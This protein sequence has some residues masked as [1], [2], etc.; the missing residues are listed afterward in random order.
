ME[1][2]EK[3]DHDLCLEALFIFAKDGMAVRPFVDFA[4][5]NLLYRVYL[6]TFE[7]ISRLAWVAL[8]TLENKQ[9]ISKILERLKQVDLKD[10]TLVALNF[11]DFSYLI[12]SL[13]DAPDKQQVQFVFDAYENLILAKNRLSAKAISQVLWAVAL[14]YRLKKKTHEKLMQNIF[15]LLQGLYQLTS[16]QL[17]KLTPAAMLKSFEKKNTEDAVKANLEELGSWEV[18][19]MIWGVSKFEAADTALTVQLLAPVFLGKLDQ[20]TCTELLMVFRVFAE[21]DFMSHTGHSHEDTVY[22]R[23][24]FYDPLIDQLATL[25]PG[26]RIDEISVVMFYLVKSPQLQYKDHTATL[27]RLFEVQEEKK[28]KIEVSAS[29]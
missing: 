12:W 5:T 26:L 2:K 3:I 10:E 20:F 4:L 25:C 15:T 13:S 16:E 9:L 7:Q 24:S 14:K 27:R 29:D 11:K 8:N 28:K 18:V 19:N 21:Q 22:V 6:L 17:A 23:S 1:S